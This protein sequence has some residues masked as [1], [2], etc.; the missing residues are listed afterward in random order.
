[1]GKF[2][3]L[4]KK[5]IGHVLKEENKQDK[6]RET[7]AVPNSVESKSLCEIGILFDIGK[8]GGG[9]YGYKAFQIF[10]K[11]TLPEKLVTSIIYDGDLLTLSVNIYCIAIQTSSPTIVS[12]IKEI[13]TNCEDPYLLPKAQRFLEG[14]NFIQRN[15]LVMSGYVD[16]K[17]YLNSTGYI[18]PD[19]TKDTK[20][21]WKN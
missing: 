19:W 1:M 18:Q 13:F 14:T 4:K 20:W 7:S 21:L 6:I 16:T 3:F 8:L 9:F 2:D 12:Y 17:G 11:N 5:N 15:S 10:F